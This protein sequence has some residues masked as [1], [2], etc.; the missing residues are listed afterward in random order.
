LP[1]VNTFADVPH[2]KVFW[3]SNG[4]Q[5]KSMGE[6]YRAI[7]VMPDHEFSDHCND[8]KNDFYNWVF[9]VVED[10]E[11][12][13][14][15]LGCTNKHT[16]ISSMQTHFATLTKSSKKPK[17]KNTLTKPTTKLKK[18]VSPL[19]FLEEKPSKKALKRTRNLR[20]GRTYKSIQTSERKDLLKR[21]KEVYKIGG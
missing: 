2:N 5:A 1:K 19:S 15:M 17:I 3:F 13:K 11:L 4:N 16:L 7:K 6:L 12:A 14:E 8:Q 10:V 9:D 21:M 20:R 18:K